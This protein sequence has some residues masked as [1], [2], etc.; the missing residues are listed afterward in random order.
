M[1]YFTACRY[2]SRSF[3]LAIEGKTEK[4]LPVSPVSRAA[5]ATT[6][7]ALF[8]EESRYEDTR[9]ERMARVADTPL[10]SAKATVVSLLK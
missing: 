9:R 3:G 2:W 7:A 5:L 4:G 6:V 10:D 1:H 8:L